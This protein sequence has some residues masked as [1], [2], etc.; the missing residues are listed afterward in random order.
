V[1]WFLPTFDII[2]EH[3]AFNH[4]KARKSVEPVARPPAEA[5]RLY[6]A[7]IAQVAVRTVREVFT[8]TPPDMVS[9]VVFTGHVDTIDPATGQ[10]FQPP[11]ISMRATRKSST[12]SC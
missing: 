3:K 5:Q 7:V 9:T 11:L 8:V 2:P 12:S 4:V 10:K 1:Q 6:N